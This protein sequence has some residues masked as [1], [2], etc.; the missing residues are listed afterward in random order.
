MNEGYQ[1]IALGLEKYFI[2]AES[3]A[4]SIK[5]TDKK[6]PI[7]IVTDQPKRFSN[8]KL[9]DIITPCRHSSDFY[10]PLIKLKCH[11][12]RIFKKTLFIDTDCILFKNIDS[13]W[14]LFKDS[15]FIIPGTIKKTGI[16]YK[17]SIED[18]CNKFNV[19]Y[20]VQM[21]SGVIFMAD[22]CEEIFDY[23][24]E[25]YNKEGNFLSH[26]HRGRGAPDEPYLG[27]A[28]GALNHTPMNPVDKK[29]NALML[30]T[31]SGHQF[32]FDISNSN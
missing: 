1:L 2:M 31:I 21:N 23:A 25:I 27:L 4:I 10:G 14:N 3:L 13:Y 29:G 19:P 8:N 11:E 16:W 30:S 26:D 6:R 32:N 22:G 17:V 18:L 15:N 20:I 5:M 24:W 7:Q 28:M 9:F 12:Y